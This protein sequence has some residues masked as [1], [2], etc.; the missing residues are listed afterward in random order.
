[1]ITEYNKPYN[2][3]SQPVVKHVGPD[4]LHAKLTDLQPGTLYE[5]TVTPI[6]DS[7]FGGSGESEETTGITICVGFV[8]S[9]R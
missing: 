8:T 9:A 4:V 3:V 2:Y 5:V 1:V 6:H 7:L